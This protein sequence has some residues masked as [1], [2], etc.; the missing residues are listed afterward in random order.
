MHIGPNWYGLSTEQ[1]KQP[2]HPEGKEGKVANKCCNLMH[3]YSLL[4]HPNILISANYDNDLSSRLLSG[5]TAERFT[6]QPLRKLLL[7]GASEICSSSLSASAALQD[8]LE[9]LPRQQTMHEYTHVHL[10]LYSE[11]LQSR[12]MYSCTSLYNN[13]HCHSSTVCSSHS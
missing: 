7:W 13:S 3:C 12:C 5:P 9:P 11:Q 2:A 10:V 4:V 6:W 8:N 1:V